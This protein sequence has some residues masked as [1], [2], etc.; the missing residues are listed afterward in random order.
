MCGPFTVPPQSLADSPL[1]YSSTA[2]SVLCGIAALGRRSQSASF[3][4][5]LLSLSLSLQHG[6]P[7]CSLCAAA[8][9]VGVRAAARVHC[10]GHGSGAAVPAR[11]R[12]RRPGGA[13]GKRPCAEP[14]GG[15]GAGRMQRA[16]GPAS[17]ACRK[18]VRGCMRV[19]VCVCVCVCV[20]EKR[21]RERGPV[22]ARSLL[23]FLLLPSPALPLRFSVRH[24]SRTAAASWSTS[25]PAPVPF[26]SKAALIIRAL[27]VLPPP[28]PPPPQTRRCL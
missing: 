24:A 14:G 27:L 22:A 18:C 28:P 15:G 13:G 10:A 25:P 16:R 3:D 21:E 7:L 17:P 9:V 19:F 4:L 20:A 6:P 2:H 12:A 8:A 11:R 23:L 1:A 26:E 5:S